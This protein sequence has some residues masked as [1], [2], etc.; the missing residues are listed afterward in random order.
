[1]AAMSPQNY[2]LR[3]GRQERQSQ[4]VF[5]SL[6]AQRWRSI[7]DSSIWFSCDDGKSMVPTRSGNVVVAGSSAEHAYVP[8]LVFPQCDVF[9]FVATS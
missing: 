4:D 5:V 6:S 3:R 8:L 7:L 2:R 1:L 9:C